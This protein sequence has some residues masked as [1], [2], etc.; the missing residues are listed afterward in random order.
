MSDIPLWT[1]AVTARDGTHVVTLTGEIDLAAADQL[2]DLL[3][4]E[5]DTPAS[6]V[7][8]A[9]LTGVTFLDSAGLGA[10]VGAYNH[11]GLAGRRF[12]LVNPGRPV[13]RI[14]EISG[15]YDVFVPSQAGDDD[16]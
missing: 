8:I 1:A 15:V 5:I 4:A 11:A 7:V 12:Q 9:D 14:L 6:V 13:K 2:L 3:R 16:R 10:F